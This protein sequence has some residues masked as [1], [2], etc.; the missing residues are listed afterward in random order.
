[1]STYLKSLIPTG[2]LVTVTKYC[3]NI[4]ATHWFNNF[5]LAVIILAGVLIGLD[6]NK[7]FVSQHKEI[8]DFLANLV[9]WIFIIEVIIKIT[10]EGK[11]PLNYFRDPWNVFDFSIVALSLAEPLIPGNTAFLPVLRLARILRVMR[12]VAA[13]PDLRLLVGTLLRSV[14]SIGYIGLFLMLLFYMFGTTGVFIFGDNDPRHFGTLPITM[15]T[16]FRVVTLEGW[17]DLMYINMYGCD[18]YGYSEY[19]HLCTDPSAM[20]VTSVIYFVSFVTIGTMIVLNLFIGVIVESMEE[21][22]VERELETQTALRLSNNITISDEFE[23]LHTQ[24]HE[25]NGALE[26]I[27]HRYKKEE[28]EKRN[29]GDRD[30]SVD[31]QNGPNV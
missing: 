4:V 2:P 18:Q 28:A 1:M 21:V 29:Q 24:L 22:K 12:L 17:T 11:D 31:D 30:P 6:T 26:L 3:R 25:L 27:R 20:P 9:L 8:L 13:I 15:L 14:S 7:Q 16:L 19:E 10:A 23:L 5:I